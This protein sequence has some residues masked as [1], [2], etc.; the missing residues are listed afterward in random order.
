MNSN[1]SGSDVE[2]IEESIEKEEICPKLKKKKYVQKFKNEWK[3]KWTWLENMKGKSYCTLCNKT[4]IGGITHL[5]R[6][7]ESIIHKKNELIQSKVPMLNLKK[8]YWKKTIIQEAELKLCMFI[9]EHNLSFRILEHL[10]KLIQSVCPDSKIAKEIK[11]GRTKGTQI[12]KE[13][14]APCSMMEICNILKTTKYS[15]IIDETTD[16]S[17]TK[18]LAVVVRY[19]DTA[20]LIIKD[21]FLTLLEVKFCT[22]EDLYNSITSFFEANEIPFEN[23]IGRYK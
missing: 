5:E 21:R 1:K 20:R 7:T 13:H 17:V 15:L 18:S 11:C 22:A 14:V 12:L 16:I 8:I 19:F 10:P 23:M 6:H 3:Q 9:S 4:L 2:M